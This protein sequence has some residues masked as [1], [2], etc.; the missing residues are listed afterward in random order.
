MA[1]FACVNDEEPGCGRAAASLVQDRD[2]AEL[3]RAE[4]TLQTLEVQ[5]RR[6][7]QAYAAAAPGDARRSDAEK[8]LRAVLSHPLVVSSSS[9]A[10]G[11]VATRA[12]KALARLRYLCARNVGR[13][14]ADDGRRADAVR[15]YL[16]V[17]LP[18]RADMVHEPRLTMDPMQAVEVEPHD[19]P[20]W[21]RIGQL[22]W[23]L[24]RYRLA[25]LALEEAW[26]QSPTNDDVYDRLLEVR[27]GWELRAPRAARR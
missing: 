21:S 19:V 6:A 9:A 16:E 2:G 1:A 15:A 26:R 22:A 23:E 25:R 27:H 24:R 11:G 4:Q 12:G 5:Y 13:M 10:A 20:L 14:A 7:L 17:R 8:D 18:L 3:A